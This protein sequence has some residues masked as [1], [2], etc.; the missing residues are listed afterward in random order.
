MSRYRWVSFTL[1]G[2]GALYLSNLVRRQFL[3]EIP[4][5]RCSGLRTRRDGSYFPGRYSANILHCQR[6]VG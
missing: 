6:V 2:E 3:A 1:R 4:S 5:G